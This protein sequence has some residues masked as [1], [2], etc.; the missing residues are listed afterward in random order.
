MATPL[1][2][3]KRVNMTMS[4]V[5]WH[6]FLPPE[7]LAEAQFVA[8]DK[9]AQFV[10]TTIVP[11][12]PHF[13]SSMVLLPSH[14]LG[15]HSRF[16]GYLLS[17]LG[18]AVH[19]LGMQM[20]E[21]CIDLQMTRHGNGDYFKRHVDAGTDDTAAR[22]ISFVCYFHLA[23]EP[24]F[25]GGSLKLFDGLGTIAGLRLFNPFATIV[26]P[27][28]NSIVFFPSEI[29]HEVERVSCSD[30]WED[31]RFSLNGWLA[32]PDRLK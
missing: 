30:K 10:P 19:E 16:V 4:H 32:M 27:D 29:T 9:R 15:L 2:N 11:P 20:T 12:R 31:G 28:H 17:R 7:I 3:H 18:Q 14:Y 24:M 5:H 1:A 25:D 26:C 21:C 22:K 13:R 8:R 6:D 23:P